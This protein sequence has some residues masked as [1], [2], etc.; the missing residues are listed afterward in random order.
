V[1]RRRCPDSS[2]R[3]RASWPNHRAHA[4]TRL[5]CRRTPSRYGS[6]WETCRRNDHLDIELGCPTYVPA[7][8]AQS[9]V[10]VPRQHSPRGPA[11]TSRP[12]TAQDL[13]IAHQQNVAHQSVGSQQNIAHQENFVRQQNI[14]RQ[15][16]SIGGVSV[17]LKAAA[18]DRDDAAAGKSTAGSPSRL[19]VGLALG[20]DMTRPRKRSKTTRP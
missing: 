19:G 1:Q 9:P 10:R 15:Q 6:S 14:A 16:N 20:S 18:E 11:R 4:T 17:S 8:V 5:S 3:P 13:Y 12:P 7:S 2:S